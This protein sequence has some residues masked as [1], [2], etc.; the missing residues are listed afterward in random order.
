MARIRTIKPEF[1]TDSFMVQLPPLARLF[2]VALWTEADDHG[3]IPD[4]PE[5]IA[6]EVMP[7]EDPHE[8]D[9]WL[10]FFI[11]AD[12][13][14][15]YVAEDGFSYLRVKNWERHQRVD[16]PSKSKLAREDSRK[17]AIPLASRRALA[18]KYGCGPGE[19]A[20]ASCYYCGAPGE[21]V[22]HQLR[23]GRPSAWVVFPGLEI[24]HL[25]AESGGGGNMQGN[26]V[27]A[28]RTCNRS[29]GTGAWYAMFTGT[30]QPRYSRSVAS[31]REGSA[32]E[33]GKE[34][35]TGK[36]TGISHTSTHARETASVENSETLPGMTEYTA[37][38]IM[39]LYGWDD[40]EGTDERVWGDT[41][42]PERSRLLKLAVQRLVAEGK[43]YQGRL[44]RRILETVI[45]EQTAPAASN[46]ARD[47]S[48]WDD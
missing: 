31:T 15:R 18:E 33:Q 36:G 1:W 41:P 40:R 37:S 29:K 20:D 44:F 7:R 10:E 2:F 8:I 46:G 25:E 26:L 42:K 35:G 13:I 3:C 12:R 28:C 14:E 22:W 47:M 30:E 45:A 21:V 11:A 38:C 34:Q 27:L 19:R 24:D 39:G 23:N 16:R 4:E 43:Q 9:G 32:L 17:L 5:R 6:M 48:H